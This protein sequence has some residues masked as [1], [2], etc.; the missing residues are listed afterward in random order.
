MYDMLTHCPLFKGLSAEAIENILHDRQYSVDKFSDGYVIARRDT[1]YSGLMIVLEGRVN[2]VVPGKDGKKMIID[3]ISAPQLIAPAF[4]FGGYNRLPI[5]VEADGDVS[6][7][8]L[9]RGLLFELM[10][11][12]TIIMSNFIDIISDRA[13]MLMKK[14][15]FLSFK[16][17]R[18]KVSRYISDHTNAENPVL[19]LGDL[20]ELSVYF[21]APRN[22]IITVLNDLNRH[23]TIKY[24]DGRIEVLKRDKLT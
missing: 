1:A 21:N 10:Q 5:D 7:M 16:N 17:I 20:N 12:D 9:H 11:D 23:G 6:I 3:T 15:Y 2:G 19:D 13:N 14:I 24:N 22:S 18:D 8:T 4:L